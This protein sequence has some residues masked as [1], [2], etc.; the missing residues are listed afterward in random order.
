MY[1]GGY[2]LFGGIFG[3]IIGILLIIAISLGIFLL[4]KKLNENGGKKK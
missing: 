1:G 4:V 3:I 2:S